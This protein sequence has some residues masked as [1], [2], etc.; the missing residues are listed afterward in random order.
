MAV[1]VTERY[2]Q[3]V[4]EVSE[5]GSPES[6]TRICGLIDVTIRRQA[7]LDSAEV[8]DCDDESLPLSLEKEVRSVEFFVDAQ[9]AIWSQESHQVLM[10]WFYSSAVKRCRVGHLAAASGDTQYEEGQGYLTTFDDSRAKGRK[11]QR[12]IA[13]EFDGTPTRIPA[14]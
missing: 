7:N 10:D 3:M 9:D 4:L 14:P 5:G 1:P 6:W 12:T 2:D 13:I 8:P 11:V